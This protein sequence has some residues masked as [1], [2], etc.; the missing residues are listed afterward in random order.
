ME[1]KH[2]LYKKKKKK[3]KKKTKKKN[4][5]TLLVK[6][7]IKVLAQGAGSLG[8][9]L[10]DGKKLVNRATHQQ[11]KMAWDKKSISLL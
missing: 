9:S 3:N 6:I 10:V 5:Y 7:E 8:C 1:N 11:E 4:T 2:L